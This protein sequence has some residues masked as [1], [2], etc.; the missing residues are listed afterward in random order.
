MQIYI[1]KANIF[2]TA[3]RLF[4]MLSLSRNEVHSISLDG[5]IWS[6]PIFLGFLHSIKFCITD[7][8]NKTALRKSEN[9]KF[10]DFI[11]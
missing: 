2:Y 4:K 1:I 9:T 8:N 3:F 5:R 10:D 7:A 11:L 6:M